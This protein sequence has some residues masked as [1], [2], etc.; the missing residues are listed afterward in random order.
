MVHRL[1]NALTELGDVDVTV[2]SLTAAPPGAKY[3]HR[4]LFSRHPWLRHNPFGRL[5]VLPA[6][7]NFVDFEDADV[8]HFHGDDWFYVRRRRPTVRTMHGSALLE[9]R[10]A[11]TWT[12]RAEQYC[13]YPLERLAASLSRVPLAI[14]KSTVQL[15]HAKQNIDNGV[16]TDLFRPG[17]KTSHPQILYVGTWTGR[18]RGEFIFNVFTR[19]VLSVYPE[20]RLCM[21]SDYCPE[22]PGVMYRR[23]PADEDL[24]QYYRESWVFAYPSTYEGFGLAYLEALASGTAVLSSPNEGASHVLDNGKYG[25]I[26]KDAEFGERLKDMIASPEIRDR[27]ASAGRIRAGQFSWRTIAERHR[28]IYREVTGSVTVTP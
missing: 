14:G 16:C 9:A 3:Q 8:L 7:L 10:A 5:I 2:Y 21:V 25:I 15:Y 17:P 28:A 18:K 23:F 4:R 1:A 22:H 19:E 11:Q 13:V 24:A 20:A 6:L 12:R 26:A 27:Y